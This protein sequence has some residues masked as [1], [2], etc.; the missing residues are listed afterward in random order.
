MADGA[1]PTIPPKDAIVLGMKYFKELMERQPTTRVLLEGLFLNEKTGDWVVT[2][3]F[4]SEQEKPLRTSPMMGAI[5]ALTL[6]STPQV[7][8]IR[9]FRAIHLSS[10]DGQFVKMEHA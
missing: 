2:F 9:E 6:M 1:S 8:I 4:D 10:T 3:G 7:E 5:S